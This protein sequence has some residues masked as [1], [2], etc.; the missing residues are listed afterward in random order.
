MGG[1]GLRW[2]LVLCFLLAACSSSA[3]TPQATPA[4][5]PSPAASAKSAELPKIEF[6][7]TKTLTKPIE[8]AIE[9]IKEVGVW[10]RLTKHLYLVKFAVY[11][12]GTMKYNKRHLA[13]ALSTVVQDEAG[14]F[15]LA[16]DIVF[17]R[18]TI[19]EESERAREYQ[20]LG[21]R[22]QF[23]SSPRLLYAEIV[24]HEL[25]HCL[26]GKSG[27]KVAQRWGKKVLRLLERKG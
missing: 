19:S 17:Y 9:D 27:E 8:R 26:E 12:R 15:Q 25:A 23:P 5:S 16:C 22:S 4:G 21:Y 3:E 7:N 11:E 18:G 2:A 24:G 6:N 20:E 13:N 1:G 10:R 14:E